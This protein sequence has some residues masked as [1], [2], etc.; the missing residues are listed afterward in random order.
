MLDASRTYSKNI[1]VNYFGPGRKLGNIGNPGN[2]GIFSKNF[3]S[4]FSILA[5]GQNRKVGNKKT[6][7][8]I[9]DIF[10]ISNF[11][12]FSIWHVFINKKFFFII[13]KY[14]TSHSY[15][16]LKIGVLKNFA[17]FIGKQLCWSVFFK[18][19]VTYQKRKKDSTTGAF[20]R[21]L[22]NF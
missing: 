22:W 4:E 11:S 5:V 1:F 6:R 8:N 17:I 16:F 12:E 14:R 9:S 2:S 13:L 18:R 7:N 19:L 20:L 3:K 21:L 10:E 15:M